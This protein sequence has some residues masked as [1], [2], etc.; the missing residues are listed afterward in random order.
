MAGTRRKLPRFDHF[1]IVGAGLVILAMMLH[2]VADVL[3][4]SFSGTLE[5]VS[6]Y[7]MVATIFLPL[8]G[9]LE[10]PWL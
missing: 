1:L 6:A 3:G 5:T 4:T 10:K 7:Y 2:I 8:P 9:H